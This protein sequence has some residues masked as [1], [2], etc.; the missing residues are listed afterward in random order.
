MQLYC[1]RLKLSIFEYDLLKPNLYFGDSSMGATS[2][3]FVGW[4][5]IILALALQP[6][7]R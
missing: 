5:D 1:I 4:E 3:F 6:S 2:Q 7:G